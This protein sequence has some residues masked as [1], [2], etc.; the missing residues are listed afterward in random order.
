VTATPEIPDSISPEMLDTLLRGRNPL[1]ISQVVPALD[2]GGELGA[3]CDLQFAICQLIERSSNGTNI[4]QM[5]VAAMHLLTDVESHFEKH[6]TS[7]ALEDEP[8]DQLPAA[9]QQVLGRVMRDHTL[10]LKVAVKHLEDVLTQVGYPYYSQRAQA[11][12]E[13]RFK[14]KR[15]LMRDF[16]SHLLIS[17]EL[18]DSL[19]VE[20]TAVTTY[21]D[22]ITDHPD[23]SSEL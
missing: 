15:V 23:D 7:L 10:G 13:D 2:F 4:I 17:D 5:L 12:I 18:L 6:L 9:D 16:R 1:P 14:A 21:L 20:R 3:P 19:E 11:L 8:Y 22:Q